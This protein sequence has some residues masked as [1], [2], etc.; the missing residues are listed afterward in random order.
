MCKLI[1]HCE[2]ASIVF[3]A[4]AWHVTLPERVYNFKYPVQLVWI[5]SNFQFE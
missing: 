2:T 4:G 1:I 5:R 3:N